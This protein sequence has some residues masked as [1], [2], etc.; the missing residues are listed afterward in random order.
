MYMY[1]FMYMYI[2][3]YTYASAS[4]HHPS[5]DISHTTCT[6]HKSGWLHGMFSSMPCYG[7]G[8]FLGPT[9]PALPATC[10]RRAPATGTEGWW[11]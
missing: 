2:Y 1:I 7:A 9:L 10:G 11:N 3:I 4:Y 8:P 6:T 5:H